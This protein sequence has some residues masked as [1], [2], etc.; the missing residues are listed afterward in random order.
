MRICEHKEKVITSPVRWTAAIRNTLSWCREQLGEL[1]RWG[2]GSD[3]VSV[4]S[5]PLR[6]R[7]R[8]QGQVVSGYRC[9]SWAT[10]WWRE[11]INLLKIVGDVDY[12]KGGCRWGLKQWLPSIRSCPGKFQRGEIQLNCWLCLLND[13]WSAADL[14]PDI[15]SEQR[16]KV[17]YEYFIVR[18]MI[19]MSKRRLSYSCWSVRK[20]M[21]TVL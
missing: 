2:Q 9:R 12:K 18:L 10:S 19:N 6:Q 15:T 8:L 17:V 1:Q 21:H 4:L 3:A 13:R 14:L 20:L 7:T 11:T 16:Y 5:F